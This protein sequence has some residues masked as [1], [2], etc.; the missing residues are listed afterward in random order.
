MDVAEEV[1]EWLVVLEI[2]AKR[3]GAP[4]EATGHDVSIERLDG[5]R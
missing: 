5:R 3:L 2:L 1:E 4:L